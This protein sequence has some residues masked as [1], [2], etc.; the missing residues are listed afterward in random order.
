MLEDQYGPERAVLIEWAQGFE[1]R[2]GKFVQEFQMTFESSMWE[3]YLNAALK[4]WGLMPDM[5]F[6]SPDFV[7]THPTK[8]AIEA[9]IAAPAQGGKSAFGYD[10]N[11]IP[12]DFS[13]FN[14]DA[15]VRI[16]NSFDAKVRRYRKYYSTMPHVAGTPFVVAI[17]AFDR[18]LAHFAAS[19][20]VIAAMYGLYHDEAATPRDADRV[21]SYNVVT[22]AKTEVV[23]IPVGLFCDNTYADVSAVIYSSLATWGK[24]RALA[25]NPAAHTI[26]RTFHPQE[27]SLFPEV[28]T[29]PKSEYHEDLMD[30]LWVLHNPFAKRPIADGALSHPRVAEV[31]V[32][33]DGELLITAPD[34]LLLLR[35]LFSVTPRRG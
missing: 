11:D 15:A 7:I 3:L 5:S 21:T 9:T 28:R 17:A 12:S 16:C 31:H 10:I 23:D 32:A 6:S 22:A 8:L 20:P 1:D 14:A 26:Y 13:K 35:T 27:G 34:D 4:P 18:P 19:R 2:D 24:I 25:D 29:S 33:P 30:G